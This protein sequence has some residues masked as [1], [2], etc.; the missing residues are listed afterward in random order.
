MDISKLELM[1]LKERDALKEGEKAFVLF[2]GQI[3]RC[4]ITCAVEASDDEQY[5][6]GGYHSLTALIDGQLECCIDECLIYKRI[7]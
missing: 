2:D 7:K 6:F 1:T 5:Y 4:T 3:R